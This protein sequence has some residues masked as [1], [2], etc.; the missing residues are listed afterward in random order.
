MKNFF[1][2]IICGVLFSLANFANALEGGVA[3]AYSILS[4]YP[5]ARRLV[6][7]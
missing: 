7:P 6:P 2:S 1:V 5:Q 4:P 3:P